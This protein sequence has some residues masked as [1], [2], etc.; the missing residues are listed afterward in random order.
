MS[1][2]SIKAIFR[3]FEASNLVIESFPTFDAT[4]KFMPMHEN[5]FLKI[6]LDKNYQ[7][8]FKSLLKIRVFPLPMKKYIIIRLCPE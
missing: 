2:N 6:P 8:K 5:V 7:N 3:Y 4:H 1:T